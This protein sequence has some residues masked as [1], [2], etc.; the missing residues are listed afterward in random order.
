MMNHVYIL[1]CTSG[2]T[3]KPT[4]QN[5]TICQRR[6]MLT[7]YLLKQ[8]DLLRFH[9]VRSN[10]DRSASA[11]RPALCHHRGWVITSLLL[12]LTTA[13]GEAKELLAAAAMLRLGLLHI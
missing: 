2:L 1:L 9:I 7:R 4:R 10:H 6:A 12:F 13:F 8:N 5:A 11:K 3:N